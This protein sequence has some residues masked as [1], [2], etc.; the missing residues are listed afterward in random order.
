MPGG[1]GGP[2]WWRL[3][4]RWMK[5]S[6]CMMPLP[7]TCPPKLVALY[8]SNLGVPAQSFQEVHEDL[9]P[10]SPTHTGSPPSQPEAKSWERIHH[11]VN[12][13]F[14][15]LQDSL[16]FGTN[17]PPAPPVPFTMG[18]FVAV[19]EQKL[20]LYRIDLVQPKVAQKWD[21]TARTLFSCS[22][23]SS[24]RPP[25]SGIFLKFCKDLMWNVC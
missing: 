15:K 5:R 10:L 25:S 11:W 17:H 8:D 2:G 16:S 3:C 9:A 4:S 23:S 20:C 6:G 18:I 22:C 24:V 7:S 13:A 12:L 21:F 14:C 19:A 1:P